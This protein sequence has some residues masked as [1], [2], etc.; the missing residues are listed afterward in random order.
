MP[1]AYWASIVL[2]AFL[3]AAIG[4]SAHEVPQ[5]VPTG[6]SALAIARHPSLAVIKAAPDFTLLDSADRRLRLSE[7]RGR[8]VLLSFIYT[9]CATTCPLLTYRMGLLRIGSRTRAYGLAR[10]ASCP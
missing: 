6:A 7:L 1:G 5:S 4:A 10:S 3:S 9:S 8:V 2:A